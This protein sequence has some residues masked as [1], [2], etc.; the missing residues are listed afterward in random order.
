[1]DYC[2][3]GDVATWDHK[4]QSFLCKWTPKEIAKFFK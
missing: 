4:N 2:K 1:M 3:F